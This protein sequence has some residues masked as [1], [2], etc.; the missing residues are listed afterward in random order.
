MI[1][2]T[3]LILEI[4]AESKEQKIIDDLLGSLQ[5]GAFDTLLDKAKKYAKS[6]LLTAGVLTALMASPQLSAA[7]K[8]QIKDIAKT[9]KTDTIKSNRDTTGVDGIIGSVTSKF[10]FPSTILKSKQFINGLLVNSSSQAFK[11][12]DPSSLVSNTNKFQLSPEQMTEWNDF[13]KW[14]KS[15]GYSGNLEMDRNRNDLKVLE[16][17]REI[18]PDFWIKS[19]EDVKKV[20][21]TLKAY[22]LLTMS[23][24]KLG[25][26][27]AKEMGLPVIV[28]PGFDHNN[29]NDVKK[30]DDVYMTWAK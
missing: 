3:K 22:R 5:E 30:L 25:P 9:Q 7:Q 2:L 8:S 18:K 15:K 16:Q 26:E 10:I 20:Q 13:V 24:W 12:G 17:Y 21:E 6:G 1:K 23:A 14:M 4:E 19:D 28:M 29:P 11:P 27:K